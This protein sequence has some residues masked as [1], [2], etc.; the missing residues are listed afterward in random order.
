LEG[1]KEDFQRW[2]SLNLKKLYLWAC[3]LEQGSSTVK[4]EKSKAKTELHSATFV[5]FIFP[6]PK[7]SKRANADVSFLLPIA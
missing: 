6:A 7:A 1:R 2:S 5:S 3:E 4:A